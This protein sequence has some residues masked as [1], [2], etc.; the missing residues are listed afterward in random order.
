MKRFLILLLILISLFILLNKK[1][2]KNIRNPASDNMLSKL[3]EAC[4]ESIK[5]NIQN[6]ICNSYSN[7]ENQ[8]KDKF[9]MYVLKNEK[10]PEQVK[11]MSAVLAKIFYEKKITFEYKTDLGNPALSISNINNDPNIGFLYNKSF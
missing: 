3:K 6:D 4:E 10:I 8:A 2:V 5:K 1:E 7:I 11:N 9:D